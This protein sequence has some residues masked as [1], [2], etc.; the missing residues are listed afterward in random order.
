MNFEKRMKKHIKKTLDA[1]TP[2]LYKKSSMPTWLKILIPSFSVIF[3]IGLL[4]AIIIPITTKTSKNTTLRFETIYVKEEETKTF[5][6]LDAEVKPWNKKTILEKYGQIHYNN[7]HYY[8]ASSPLNVLKMPEDNVG[9]KLD[10]I[11]LVGYDQLKE[12][13]EEERTISAE[14][15]AIKKMQS[16][17]S[18]AIK[19]NG[20][21]GF[22]AYL[23]QNNR[24]D[25]MQD[26][27]DELSISQTV[28]F[29]NSFYSEYKYSVNEENGHFIRFD[30]FDD[31]NIY[32]ILFD[33]KTLENKYTTYEQYKF[34][35]PPFIRVRSSIPFFGI[36]KSPT[37]ICFSLNEHGYMFFWCCSNIS[38]FYIGVDRINAF[39]DYLIKNVKGYELIFEQTITYYD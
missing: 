31:D 7:G 11:V 26:V 20:Y 4:F 17:A 19:F 10:D 14:I 32:K 21:D 1:N 12:T 5:E 16:K 22:Y 33:D 23:N 24:F 34:Y 27:F 38:I 8:Y 28:N 6:T 35:Y 13:T 39:V 2:N 15:Y 37:R 36:N 18:I 29:T 3:T 9:E 30:D 25:T